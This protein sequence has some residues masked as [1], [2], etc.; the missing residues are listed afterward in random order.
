MRE[1]IRSTV[2]TL[3]KKYGTHEPEEICLGI[4]IPIMLY[5][6]PEVTNGFCLMLSEGT[7]IVLNQ[8]LAHSQRRAV[9]AHELGH[10]VL[11]K[12]FNYMFMTEHTN[13]VTGKF[14]READLFA[15][16]LLLR[17]ETNFENSTVETIAAKYFLST[18]AV[19][20]YFGSEQ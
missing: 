12:G 5:D 20:E 6:L 7:V 1:G 17:H 2:E 8:N 14:E 13:M 16:E 4:G 18:S 19:S 9:L 10:A 3:T 11:H 15:A